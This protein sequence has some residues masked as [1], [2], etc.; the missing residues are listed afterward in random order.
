MIEIN[1]VL[2]EIQDSDFIFYN[3]INVYMHFQK[4]KPLGECNLK[5]VDGNIYGDFKLNENLPDGIF[6]PAIGYEKTKSIHPNRIDQIGICRNPNV[7][8]N[9]PCFPNS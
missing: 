9:I 3:P 8:V 7:D 2:V 1:N 4:D 6:W 5:V